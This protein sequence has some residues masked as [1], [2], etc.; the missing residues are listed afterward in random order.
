L[1]GN[2]ALNTTA[3]LQEASDHYTY[4]PKRPVPTIGGN[5]A[6]HPP[7]VGPYDQTAVELRSDVLVYT[8]DALQEALEV[9]GPIVLH[10]FA[11]TNRTDTDFTGKLIDLYP[12]GYA[13]ILLE[14]VI[15]GRYWKTFR[16]QNLLTPNNVYEFYVDLWSTSNLFQ[17]GHR[18]RIE[19]SS[20]NFPKYNTNPNTGH[21]FG[22]DSE[23]VIANQT[24]YHDKAHSSYILL[25]IIPAGSKPCQ[26]SEVAKF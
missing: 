10:L 19:V 21:K 1:A 2:G 6:M 25:P 7:R 4:D 3:P 20:S 13:Q 9:T 16:E 17:K 22:D 8:S 18:I 5:V 15:R 23:S 14:G 12:N 11:S 24:I 26:N